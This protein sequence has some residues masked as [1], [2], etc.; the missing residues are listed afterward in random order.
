ML[1]SSA[2]FGIRISA[3]RPT[4]PR[5]SPSGL[6]IANSTLKRERRNR[7]LFWVAGVPSSCATGLAGPIKSNR[8]SKNRAIDVGRTRVLKRENSEFTFR[9]GS[10]F[11][12]LLQDFQ[13][14]TY[15]Y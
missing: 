12:R 1:V 14:K 11:M 15:L 13:F 8:A 3:T 5:G 2:S 9:F 4:A 10:G 6:S 7:G